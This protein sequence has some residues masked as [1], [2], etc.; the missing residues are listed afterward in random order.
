MSENQKL[1]LGRCSISLK[2]K[3]SYDTDLSKKPP[4]KAK[5]KELFSTILKN[6]E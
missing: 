6:L 3:S 4:E 2:I 5:L 1:I